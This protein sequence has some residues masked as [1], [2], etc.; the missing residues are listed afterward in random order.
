MGA[1]SDD[2]LQWLVW[3]ILFDIETAVLTSVLKF[4]ERKKQNSEFVSSPVAA[5]SSSSLRRR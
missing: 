3:F 2:L 1:A 5:S 4:I